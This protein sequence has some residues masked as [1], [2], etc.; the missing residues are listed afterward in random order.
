VDAIK[1]AFDG[2]VSAIRSM[3][4]WLGKIKMPDALSAIGDAIGSITPWAVTPP[5]SGSVTPVG[6]STFAAP[7]VT[8]SSSGSGAT[9]VIQGA[10]DPVA[11]ARQI[12]LILRNDERR[13][14]GVVIA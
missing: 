1:A 5:S 14:S 3:I 13:R 10:L 8:S 4:D 2:V 11:V 6:V 7:G 9:I 12:R